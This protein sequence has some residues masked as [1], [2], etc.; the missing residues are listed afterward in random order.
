MHLIGVLFSGFIGVI[1]GI[2][3]GVLIVTAFPPSNER[4]WNDLRYDQCIER[5]E[6]SRD[7]CWDQWLGEK[8]RREEARRASR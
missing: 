2:T 6:V 4:D 3:T 1:I 8:L 5:N 7:I